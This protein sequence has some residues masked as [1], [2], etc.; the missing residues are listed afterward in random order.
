MFL[1]MTVSFSQKKKKW[2]QDSDLSISNGHINSEIVLSSANIK[3]P[4]P[5]KELINYNTQLQLAE[6]ASTDGSKSPERDRRQSH[7]TLLND[8]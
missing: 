2:K 8:P 4:Y 1:L 7:N 6:L 5:C 3:L